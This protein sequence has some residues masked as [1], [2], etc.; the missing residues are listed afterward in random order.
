MYLSESKQMRVIVLG[1]SLSLAHGIAGK[2][3]AFDPDSGI[4]KESG[5]FDLFKFGFFSYQEGRKNDAVE[6]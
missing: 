4:T 1:L 5:P 2:A 3:L 6:A